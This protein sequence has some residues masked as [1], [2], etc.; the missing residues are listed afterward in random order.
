MCI[1][2][3]KG[4]TSFGRHTRPAC[5]QALRGT[6]IK[7]NA[8]ILSSIQCVFLWTDGDAR[9]L[10]LRLSVCACAV[11][12]GGHRL[13][14]MR[15][16][17][18]VVGRSA[19]V[20]MIPFTWLR[21]GNAWGWTAHASRLLPGFTRSIKLCEECGSTSCVWCSFPHGVTWIGC[22]NMG[23]CDVILVTWAKCLILIGSHHFLLRSDWLGPHVAPMTTYRNS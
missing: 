10:G 21:R 6:F 16:T 2:V 5:N 7:T 13:L 23:A 4:V 8:V 12:L 15:G 11:G 1:N 22:P 18:G 9:G 20:P 3:K 14:W 17:W 19:H